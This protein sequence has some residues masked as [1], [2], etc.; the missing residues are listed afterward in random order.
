MLSTF[1]PRLQPAW[2]LARHGGLAVRGHRLRQV[3]RAVLQKG[4]SISRYT[5]EADMRL[6]RPHTC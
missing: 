6:W 1:Y 2:P 4:Q 3:H 5:V